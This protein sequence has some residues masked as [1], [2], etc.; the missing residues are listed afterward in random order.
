MPQRTYKQEQLGR[1]E[2]HPGGPFTAGEYTSFE[3]K[4]LVDAFATYEYVEL[5][6]SPVFRIIA[7]PAVRWRAVLPTLRGVLEPFPLGFKAEDLWGNPTDITEQSLR[8]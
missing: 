4:V 3:L 8:F 1:A 6:Q 5:P 7:G 2:I